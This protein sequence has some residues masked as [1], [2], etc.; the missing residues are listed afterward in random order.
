MNT[1]VIKFLN[2]VL[3][4]DSYVFNLTHN[5]LLI[6]LKWKLLVVSCDAEVLGVL[7]RQDLRAGDVWR[8]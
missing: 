2:I 4:N 3:R 7:L 6:I 5:L 8:E 1:K